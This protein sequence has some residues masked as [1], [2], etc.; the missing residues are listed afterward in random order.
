MNTY[1][2]MIVD[3]KA[4]NSVKSLILSSKNHC[5]LRSINKRVC[6]CVCV[7]RTCVWCVVVL[8]RGLKADCWPALSVDSVT[9]PTVWTSRWVTNINHCQH[10]L[11]HD[12]CLWTSVHRIVW[13]NPASTLI[14]LPVIWLLC[15]LWGPDYTCG[16][17]QRVALSGV[18]CVWGVRRGQWPRATVVMWWLWHQLPHLLPGPAPSYCT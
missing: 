8:V 18:Y 3:S 1:N 7:C 9:I 15:L 6:V 16:P 13:Y 11:K 2:M 5:W 17:D 10:D 12:F 4:L 14:T